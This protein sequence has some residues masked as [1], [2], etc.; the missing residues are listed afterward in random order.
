MHVCGYT[1]DLTRLVCPAL[2]SRHLITQ[3]YC[4][5]FFPAKI[6]MLYEFC[7]N[8][9]FFF[10]VTL[11]SIYWHTFKCKLW[12]IAIEWC[13]VCPK[14]S[15]LLIIKAN[16]KNWGFFLFSFFFQ[17]TDPSDFEKN[18]CSQK[19]NWSGLTTI[20]IKCCRQYCFDLLGL[21]SAVLML[22]L[23]EGYIVASENP[24]HVG[25]SY[26]ARMLKLEN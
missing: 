24:M 19:Y 13:R 17:L 14:E 20:Y 11:I 22:K 23:R 12:N 15:F 21:I 9:F 8:I 18:L 16:A 4:C 7:T 1:L 26:L 6:E 25:S 3:K 5:S 10:K 2:Q